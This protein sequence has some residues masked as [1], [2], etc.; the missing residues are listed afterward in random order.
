MKIGSQYRGRIDDNWKE[1]SKVTKRELQMAIDRLLENKN[2]D[3]ETT[4]SMGCSIK[5]RNS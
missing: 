5:W 4:P 3:F 1:E 2:I